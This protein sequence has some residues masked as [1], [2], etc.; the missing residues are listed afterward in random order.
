MLTRATSSQAMTA[1]LSSSRQPAPQLP[2]HYRVA[3][4]TMGCMLSHPP[5]PSIPYQKNLPKSYQ[6]TS[7]PPKISPSHQH[8]PNFAPRRPLLHT[9]SS[10]SHTKISPYQPRSVHT[11]SHESDQMMSAFHANIFEAKDEADQKKEGF[12]SGGE[13]HLFLSW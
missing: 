10:L 1:K 7:R 6:Q 3:T 4:C 5:C 13:I 11:T 9:P 8:R 2:C 12:R